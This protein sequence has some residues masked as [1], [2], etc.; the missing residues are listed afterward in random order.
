MRVELDRRA[1]G[2]RDAWLSALVAMLRP[3][4]SLT[5]P[6][7]RFLRLRRVAITA[8]ATSLLFAFALTLGA[9]RTP[10]S[11]P[12]TALTSATCVSQPAQSTS[13]VPGVPAVRCTPAMPAERVAPEPIAP[14]AEVPL[15]SAT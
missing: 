9:D 14:A 12:M 11:V 2:D 7:A 5:A 15:H 10:T 3:S 1:H 13:A 6:I 8:A 4:P